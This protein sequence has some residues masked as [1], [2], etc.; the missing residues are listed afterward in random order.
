[1]ES[2]ANCADGVSRHG[3][4][5]P[6]IQQFHMEFREVS[7]PNFP[8]LEEAPLRALADAFAP[9]TAEDRQFQ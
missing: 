1:M 4:F 9:A 5:A 3:R 6:I 2:K 7:L 8:V